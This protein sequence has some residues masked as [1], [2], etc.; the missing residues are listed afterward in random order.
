MAIPAYFDKYE[1]LA[2]TRDADGVLVL[3][4]HTNGGPIVFTGKTHE[5]FPAALE[6]MALDTDNTALVLTGTGDAFMDQIDGPSLGEIFK[7]GSWEKTRVE[8][9]TIS[10]VI[11]ARGICLP[12]R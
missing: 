4:F 8:G 9:V 11:F 2:F 10:A 3:R 5:Q 7:P 6:E 1:N 12:Y